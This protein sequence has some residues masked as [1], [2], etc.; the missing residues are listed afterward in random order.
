VRILQPPTWA[1]P[2]GYSNGIVASGHLVFISGQ[3]GWD[4]QCMFHT[5]DFVEQA[6]Q[7]LQNVLAVLAE[8]GGGCEHLTRLTWYVVDKHEYVASYRAL[9]AVYRELMGNHYPAMTAVEVA[10]LIADRARVE[11]EAI[12]VVPYPHGT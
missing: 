2:R 3:I 8:A 9:G 7:A 10:G 5:D 11:I 4:E 12:A 6:R 1:R